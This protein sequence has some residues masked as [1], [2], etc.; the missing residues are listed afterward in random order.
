[1]PRLTT[2]SLDWVGFWPS[3]TRQSNV[4]LHAGPSIRVRCGWSRPDAVVR[5]PE[6]TGGAVG[7]GAA[8]RGRIILTLDGVIGRRCAWSRGRGL[9]EWG[10]AVRGKFLVG[11]VLMAYA[12]RIARVA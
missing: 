5:A 3:S 9:V 12:I 1:M 7:M 6:R 2:R 8:A 4:R 10:Q 11:M